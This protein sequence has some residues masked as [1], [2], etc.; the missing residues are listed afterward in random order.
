MG[1]KALKN[2]SPRMEASA[3]HA[4]AGRTLARLRESVPGARF[5]VIPAY[6]RKASFGD[7]DIVVDWGSEEVDARQRRD[8]AMKVLN[9]TEVV[10]NHDVTSIGVASDGCSAPFQLDLITAPAETFDFT[11]AYF[12]FNDLGNLLGRVAHMAGFKLGHQGLR[13]VTRNPRQSHHVI[14]ETVVTLEWDQALDFLGY[15]PAAYRRGAEGGFQSLED[16]FGFVVSSR[17]FYAWSYLPEN[18][19]HAA[20]VRDAKRPTYA[21]FL[22]WLDAASH[23]A[24]LQPAVDWTDKTA[25]RA[26]FLQA[27]L[28]RFPS[29]RESHEAAVESAERASLAKQRL[30]MERVRDLT[31]AW[32]KEL[33]QIFREVSARFEGRDLQTAWL[34]QASD[35]A[36]DAL[37]MDAAAKVRAAQSTRQLA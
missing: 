9:P 23:P 24:V 6:G 28:A 1:G 7:M 13:Y 8:L 22:R 12:S 32:G 36:I 14:A 30:S 17:Y 2:P 16:I 26:E 19:N 25:R 37:V 5:E 3:Y 35:Q 34:L 29:F 31:G 20:R 33:S 10:T 4:F 21:A 27:A 11:L 18:M 15:D